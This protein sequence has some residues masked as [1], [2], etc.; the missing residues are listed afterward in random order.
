MASRSRALPRMLRHS[1]LGRSLAGFIAVGFALVLGLTAGPSVFPRT[2][3]PVA[4]A[5]TP[6]PAVAPVGDPTAAITRPALPPGPDSRAK[7]EAVTRG[8]SPAP[9][10]VEAHP[11]ATHP[12]CCS[13]PSSAV[14][15]PQAGTPAS[16]TGSTAVASPEPVGVGLDFTARLLDGTEFRLGQQR[17]RVV[18]IFTVTTGACGACIPHTQ[19]WAEVSARY[20]PQDLVVLALAI[21]P[22]DTPEQVAALRAM[23]GGNLTWALYPEGTVTRRL[24]LH[25]LNQVVIFNR[26]G[27]VAFQG[28]PPSDA[29]ALQRLVAP[30][31]AS[32]P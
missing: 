32:A 20:R 12:P 11:P 14:A 9:L 19:A 27:Q 29:D 30:L 2:Q 21:S 4:P 5:A 25:D 17:G 8:N 15:A 3:S 28:Y 31:I 22:L 1:G 24:G 23:F 10:T 18:A 7:P 26:E 13:L 6:V 16:P